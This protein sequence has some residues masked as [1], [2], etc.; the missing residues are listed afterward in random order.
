MK[1]FEILQL[2]LTCSHLLTQ[3]SERSSWKW[4]RQHH[5]FPLIK[6]VLL[7]LINVLSYVHIWQIF[8]RQPGLQRCMEIWGH[9]ISI[10]K[11]WCRKSMEL[12]FNHLAITRNR[13]FNFTSKNKYIET[14]F[15]KVF[16][17]KISGCIKHI[18]CLSHIINNTRLKQRGCVE[19]FWRDKP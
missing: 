6:S 16:F 15:K 12:S 13:L 2:I 17:G 8:S 19:R 18:K 9:S 1:E 11:W 5:L 7:L 10:Q 4:N 14:N 3:K